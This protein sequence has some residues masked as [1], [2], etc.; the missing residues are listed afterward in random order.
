LNSKSFIEPVIIDPVNPIS[1]DKSNPFDNKYYDL[2]LAKHFE[3]LI[4]NIT[5]ENFQD[6]R[7]EIN[8]RL[9][10]LKLDKKYHELCILIRQKLERKLVCLGGSDWICI[11]LDAF[12]YTYKNLG[13]VPPDSIKI[14][15]SWFDQ[16]VLSKATPIGAKTHDFLKQLYF[17]QHQQPKTRKKVIL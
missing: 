15:Q 17:L 4:D 1:L 12:G 7:R 3:L 11:V 6:I 16:G 8:L 5:A 9:D 13:E 14:L 2:N 10:V